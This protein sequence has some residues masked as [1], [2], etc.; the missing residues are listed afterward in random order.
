MSD[1]RCPSCG[2]L[3]AKRIEGGCAEVRMSGKLVAVVC[4]GTLGCSCGAQV[5]LHVEADPHVLLVRLAAVNGAPRLPS[6]SGSPTL[7]PSSAGPEPQPRANK[8]G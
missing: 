8:P 3:L 1:V 4:A 7:G 5:M 2:K 6:G